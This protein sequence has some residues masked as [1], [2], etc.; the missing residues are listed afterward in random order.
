MYFVDGIEKRQLSPEMGKDQRSSIV[1][2][3]PDTLSW[4]NVHRFHPETLLEIRSWYCIVWSGWSGGFTTLSP[5]PLKLCNAEPEEGSCWTPKLAYLQY[6]T[7]QQRYFHCWSLI[8]C[9]YHIASPQPFYLI[10]TKP[11]DFYPCSELFLNLPEGTW[12]PVWLQEAYVH[13]EEALCFL[14]PWAWCPIFT[15][16]LP[17]GSFEEMGLVVSVPFKAVLSP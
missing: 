4:F 5:C 16:K 12:K 11:R 1:R 8:F 17:F 14:C 15:R 3:K 2:L 9:Q 7:T 13:C 6:L 10:S